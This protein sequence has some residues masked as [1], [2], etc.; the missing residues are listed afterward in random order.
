[1]KM[2]LWQNWTP[3]NKNKEKTGTVAIPKR[4]VPDSIPSAFVLL[5]ENPNSIPEAGCGQRPQ[6]EQMIQCLICHTKK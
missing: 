2:Q 4:S 3:L 5:P 6:N 1:M